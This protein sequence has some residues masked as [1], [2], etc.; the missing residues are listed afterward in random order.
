ML[1]FCAASDTAA[2]AEDPFAAKLKELQEE[3]AEMKNDRL[4]MLAEME[5]VRMIARRDVDTAKTYA[6]QSFA[7]D[8]LQVSDTLAMAIDS[9]PA[10]ELQKEDAKSLR[11]LHE[12]VSMTRHSLLKLFGHNGMKEV[13]PRVVACR[14]SH[15]FTRV[16]VC[17]SLARWAR[18]LMRTSTKS[19]LRCITMTLTT[20]MLRKSSSQASCSRTACCGLPRLEL[21]AKPQSRYIRNNTHLYLTC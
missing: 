9:V 6:I 12:G 21:C 14:L 5:N 1:C 20:A 10:D 3:L 17:C 15:L 2:V 18:N 13:W 16:S 19:C 4:R 7:K 11:L 8:L